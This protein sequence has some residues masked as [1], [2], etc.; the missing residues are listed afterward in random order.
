VAVVIGT[1]AGFVSA[2]PTADPS[3]TAAAMDNQTRAI[4]DT[5]PSGTNSIS[6]IGWWC[7][8]ATEAANFE[9]GVYS[10]DAGNNRP[11]V[12]LAS[13]RTNAKGTDAGWKSAAVAYDLSATTVYWVAV[14]LDDTATTTNSDFGAAAGSRRE[15]ANTKTTLPESWDSGGSGTAD[16]AFAFYALYAAAGGAGL[17]MDLFDQ[18]T[19]AHAGYLEAA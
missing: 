19:Y 9:V 12:L 8:N 3:G 13:A 6:S 18:F 5:S 14:Q 4:K 16:S 10:H 11:N 1:S 2:A 17:P 15:Y 7:D